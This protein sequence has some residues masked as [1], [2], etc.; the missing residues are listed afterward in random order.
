MFNFWEQLALELEKLNDGQLQDVNIEFCN[1][2]IPAWIAASIME[3]HKQDE[4]YI[5]KLL[6]ELDVVKDYMR[7]LR[8]E[9]SR[10]KDDLVDADRLSHD[11]FEEL[12]TYKKAGFKVAQSYIKKTL[13]EVSDI[14]KILD[15]GNVI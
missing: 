3:D 9:N 13:I 1:I 14:I 4:E 15:F 5:N 12:E 7:L 8:K 6:Y 2:K 11:L 10:L